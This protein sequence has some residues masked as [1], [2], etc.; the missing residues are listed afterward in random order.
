MVTGDVEETADYIAKQVGL[1]EVYANCLPGDKV[2][3][4][5]GLTPHAVLMVGDG[6][7]DA[8]VL[9][10]ADVGIALG[11][12]GSTAASESAD[13]V[14]L[15]DDLERA[16]QAVEIGQRTIRIAL[17]SIWLGIVISVGLM[18]LAAF[19]FLPAVI[20]AILQEVVDLVA[21]LGALRAV[22]G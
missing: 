22:R 21:I 16:A 14:I 9:A 17:E 18:V 19:G 13:V 1:S 8:P 15:L 20:G 12:R 3:I 10:V 2:E 5:G 6:V 4:I 11:A 7:N